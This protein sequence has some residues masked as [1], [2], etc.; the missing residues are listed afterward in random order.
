M[1]Q[2]IDHPSLEKNLRFSHEKEKESELKRNR[3]KKKEKEKIFEKK[4]VSQR[5]RKEKI[6]GRT[7]F[8]GVVVDSIVFPLMVP[9]RQIP[10]TQ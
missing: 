9:K 10:L 6:Q 1:T 5:K 2:K 8:T 7:L 3:P 4:W